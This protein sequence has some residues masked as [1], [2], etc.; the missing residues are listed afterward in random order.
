MSPAAC[1]L[2]P[3]VETIAEVVARLA[4]IQADLDQNRPSRDGVG[5]FN[6]LYAV[7]TADV[8]MG[9][10][11]Q[12]YVDNDFMADLDVAFANR[13]FD[14]LRDDAQSPGTAPE[15]WKVLLA[16]RDDADIASLQFA[17]A[18]VNA[19]I[20]FDLAA[21]VVEVWKKRGGGPHDVKQHVTYQQID[22]V[23]A[24]E[25]S[26]LRHKFETSGERDLD[27][28]QMRT[29]LNF[30]SDWTV[31]LSRDLAWGHASMMWH[32]RLLGIDPLYMHGLSLSAGIAG[33]TILMH[34]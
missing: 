21:A 9:V 32:A 5:C 8:Q 15:P 2:D 1:Y 17:V 11:D 33:D 7:I 24:K 18:G 29:F 14:A 4:A 13:Y 16:K 19:H 26:K 12:A 20:D 31:N 30:V 34:L 3:A 23:F 28:G 6:K 25:M 10:K 22:Q 27:K